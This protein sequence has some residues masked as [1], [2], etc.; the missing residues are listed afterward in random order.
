MSARGEATLELQGVRCLSARSSA[1]SVQGVR[2]CI[3]LRARSSAQIVQAVRWVTN[4]RARSCA[5]SLQGVRWGSNLRARS[6]APFLQGVRWVT[7]MRARSC[8][9]YMQRVRWGWNMRARSSAPFVQGVRWFTN[10]RARSCALSVQGVWWGWNMRARSS[11]H[12]MQGVSCKGRRGGV[13]RRHLRF[14]GE[15]AGTRGSHGAHR[16][17]VQ[18]QGERQRDVP[19]ASEAGGE[20]GEGRGDGAVGPTRRVC[21]NDHS[22]IYTRARCVVRCCL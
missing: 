4:L 7:N 13:A 17:R 1:L 8:T 6:S 21:V 11:A 5:L 3:N 22:F 20:A 16:G 10:L 12:F 19:K 18:P 15:S 9:L 14:P 2:W